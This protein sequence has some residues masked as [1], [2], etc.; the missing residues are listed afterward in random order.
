[1]EPRSGFLASPRRRRR[2]AWSGGV[3]AFLSGLVA[4]AL[5][6]PDVERPPER[7]SNEPAVLPVSPRNVPLTKEV[8][9]AT[10][11]TG[12]T[13]LH[14]AVARDHPERSWEIVDPTLREGYTKRSWATGEIPVV[15]YP[16]DSAIYRLDFSHP[17][18]VGWKVSV[19]PRPGSE[20]KPMT[21]YMDVTLVEGRWRVS[22]WS[23]ASL[24]SAA[25]GGDA[26]EGGGANA[27]AIGRPQEGDEF[28][29]RVSPMWLL[30]PVALLGLALVAI[31]GKS[32][33]DWRR[34][35]AVERAYRSNSN[36][37]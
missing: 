25:P 2:L 30:L 7:M 1:V 15:P 21:F 31:G 18:L 12:N 27:F 8:K 11:E 22:N 29:S 16:V 26:S 4:F 20:T 5:L 3:L 9:A 37:S 24:A 34:A 32:V 19:Y 13:F 6:Y 14:S 28:E 35:A 17:G 10:I 33:R 23:P 36:P